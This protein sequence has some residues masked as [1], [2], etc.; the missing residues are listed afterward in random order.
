MQSLD[1][2]YT[3]EWFAHDFEHLQPEFDVVADSLVRQFGLGSLSDVIDL[4]CGPGMVVRRLRTHG[5][6]AIGVDG[7]S[8]AL[9]YAHPDVRDF[10]VQGDLTKPSA[11]DVRCD[12]LIC[13][14]VAEHLDT[15]HA[16]G[17]VKLLTSYMC[18]VVFTAAP[19]GQDG[20]HHVNCQPQSYWQ[21]LFLN[22]GA[23]QDY[24]ATESLK[25]RWGALKR[26]SHMRHNVMVF[27]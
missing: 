15:E 24:T 17:L 26:L 16:P 22:H 8:H 25:R 6:A 23:V 18:P 14:E 12:L 4:G 11:F 3:R 9:E 20:H 1:E 2:I 13:T 5:V 19:P 27:I 21:D 10:L 7:S